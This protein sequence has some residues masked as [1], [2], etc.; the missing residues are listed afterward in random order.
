M[1]HLYGG[2]PLLRIDLIADILAVA[3]AP[4]Y[5]NRGYGT[6]LFERVFELIRPMRE[7]GTVTD[8][9][10]TVTDSNHR[11]TELF[12]RLGFEI[13]IDEDSS[14]SAAVLRPVGRI[15]H[16]T[17]CRA[18]T[19]VLIA[20]LAQGFRRAECLADGAIPDG[21]HGDAESLL[22]GLDQR[23]RNETGLPVVL[24]ED[25]LS[26]VVLGTGRVLEEIDLLRKVSIR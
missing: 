22:R 10:L 7:R 16:L 20:G 11:G 26:S 13:Q 12:R 8:L 5:Q 3:V 24:A 15:D 14:L 2:E 18:E 19:G 1:L 23:L 25:P 6:A 9:R 21:V 17:V 4:G